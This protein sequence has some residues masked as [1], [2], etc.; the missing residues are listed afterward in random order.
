MHF[1]VEDSL[2]RQ[3]K[4]HI[5]DYVTSYTGPCSPVQFQ[6]KT[7]SAEIKFFHQ[8][9]SMEMDSVL[10]TGEIRTPPLLLAIREHRQIGPLA[11]LTEV[12]G[13]R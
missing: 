8:S 13:L 4:L 12:P 5:G 11:Y 10:Y 7:V 2:R 1:F 9:H 6:T 3:L